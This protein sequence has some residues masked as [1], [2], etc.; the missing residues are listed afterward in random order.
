MSTTKILSDEEFND[1]L[2]RQANG[3]TAR[4]LYKEAGMSEGAFYSRKLALYNKRAKGGIEK[5]RAVGTVKKSRTTKRKK[6]KTNRAK[7]AA[8]NGSARNE[9]ARDSLGELK[10][11]YQAACKDRDDYKASYK[12][13]RDMY[14]DRA[15]TEFDARKQTTT[16]TP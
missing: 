7:P 11:K 5:S 3:E 1:L 12:K 4:S 2:Q 6:K 14:L 10:A 8:K 9:S 13:L 16:K 15:L